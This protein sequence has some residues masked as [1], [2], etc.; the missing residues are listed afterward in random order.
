MF[1]RAANPPVSVGA[2]T[3]DLTGGGSSYRP[4][5]WAPIFADVGTP[6]AKRDD[7]ANR[8]A[9]LAKRRAPALA[10]VDIV[11]RCRWAS[12]GA[13]CTIGGTF[14][15]TPAGGLNVS[16]YLANNGEL[17]TGRRAVLAEA[18]GIVSKTP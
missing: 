17:V 2:R 18:A 5:V 13:T 9:T 6:A 4:A 16:D 14:K 1:R 15:T 7:L 3:P 11:F 10:G 12:E 8:G